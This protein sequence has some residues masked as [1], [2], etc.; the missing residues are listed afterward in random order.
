M[1][2][3]LGTGMPALPSPF[4]PPDFLSLVKTIGATTGDHKGPPHP[5]AP[6]SP[7]RRWS[8]SDV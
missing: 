6:R 3:C 4:L 7:L 5:S 1:A 2:S 8:A